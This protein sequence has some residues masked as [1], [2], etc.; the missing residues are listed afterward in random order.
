MQILNHRLTCLVFCLGVSCQLSG[1]FFRVTLAEDKTKSRAVPDDIWPNDEQ[2]LLKIHSGFHEP[3][4]IKYRL[5]L[6]SSWKTHTP[7]AYAFA[8]GDRAMVR[9]LLE[10]GADPNESITIPGVTPVSPLQAAIRRQEREAVEFLFKVGAKPAMD[11]LTDVGQI[12]DPKVQIEMTRLILEAGVGAPNDVIVSHFARAATPE[13]FALLFKHGAK[14]NNKA[15]SFQMRPTLVEAIADTKKVRIAIEQ[16][17]DPNQGTHHDIDTPLH[18]CARRG[19][20]ATVGLLVQSGARINACNVHGETPIEVAV[21]QPGFFAFYRRGDTSLVKALLSH[22]AQTSI[23]VDVATGNIKALQ[24]R[25]ENGEPIVGLPAL[26][27][28]KTWFG[29]NES[30]SDLIAIAASFS[31]PESLKWLLENDVRETISRLPNLKTDRMDSPALVTAAF[32]GDERSVEI[33]LKYGSDPN[34]TS[35]RAVYVAAAF[36]PLHAVLA[37]ASGNTYYIHVP[38]GRTVKL[39]EQHRKI[40]QLLVNHGADPDLENGYGLTPREFAEKSLSEKMLFKET[41]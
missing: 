37:A 36:T 38:K 41:K 17:A 30:R 11:H 29:H 15:G 34:E 19:N 39:S 24:R 13:A 35:P 26:D 31:Q 14:V 10:H 18:A 2:P 20:A 6:A 32:H 7:L 12:Q 4:Q 28:E 27:E 22:G 1:L 23:A 21:T 9:V 3:N 16:G 25:N 40:I 5:T 8:Q 33:L